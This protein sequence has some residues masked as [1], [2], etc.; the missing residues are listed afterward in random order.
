MALSAT[1]FI[2]GDLIQVRVSLRNLSNRTIQLSSNSPWF[3]FT[4]TDIDGMVF[5]QWSQHILFFSTDWILIPGVE[6]TYTQRSWV[7]DEQ[8]WG[9]I[10]LWLQK[11]KY[12]VTEFT[13]SLK[14][15][16]A[17]PYELI[18][19]LTLQTPPVTITIV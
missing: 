18:G 3:D 10:P 11:G 9:D 6:E 8:T 7:F 4:I 19:F 14:V 1:V 5:F 13:P 16:Y 2:Q 15:A 12:N 17:K